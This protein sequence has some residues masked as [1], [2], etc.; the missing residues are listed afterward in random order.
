[1]HLEKPNQHLKETT[2]DL[3]LEVVQISRRKLPRFEKEKAGR[4]GEVEAMTD[5]NVEVFN[6]ESVLQN[7]H[8]FLEY[9][10]LIALQC[11]HHLVLIFSDN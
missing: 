7:H 10:E 5:A 2:M 9:M 11:S 4:V 6:V 1:M 8:Q 3:P